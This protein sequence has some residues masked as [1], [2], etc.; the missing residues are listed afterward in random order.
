[1]R[2][3]WLLKPTLCCLPIL[4]PHT[5][6]AQEHTRLGLP[7]GAV[8]RLGKGPLATGYQLVA[9]SPDG[10]RL[11]VAGRVGTWLYDAETMAKVTLLPGQTL[12]SSVAF[13]P[14]GT[15]LAT[16]RRDTTVLKV[17]LLE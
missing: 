5:S 14:D 8:A 12:R 3:N 9:F 11:A 17:V 10:T 4:F 6:H 1:M 13:S 15:T 7:E 16:V 2:T